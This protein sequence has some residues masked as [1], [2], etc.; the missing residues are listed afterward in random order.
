MMKVVILIAEWF[1]MMIMVII[2][3]DDGIIV[4]DGMIIAEWVEGGY[5]CD[6]KS[7]PSIIIMAL[8]LE[9]M[10]LIVWLRFRIIFAYI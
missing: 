5:G 6:F 7:R 9:M 4:I 1:V 3:I 8:S 2:N 10:M